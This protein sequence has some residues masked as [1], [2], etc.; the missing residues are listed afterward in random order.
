MTSGLR[1]ATYLYLIQEGSDSKEVTLSQPFEGVHLPLAVC[2]P[3]VWACDVEKHL[4]SFMDAELQLFFL[5]VL[6]RL[7]EIALLLQNVF[8]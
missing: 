3:S 2:T 5:L 1:E 8:S 7:S 4:L 6:E